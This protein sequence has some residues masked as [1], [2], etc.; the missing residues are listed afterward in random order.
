MEKTSYKSRVY[1]KPLDMYM[2][3]KKEVKVIAK[4][5]FFEENASKPVY[6]NEM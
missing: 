3:Y 6:F 2:Y 5:F 1:V 4:P